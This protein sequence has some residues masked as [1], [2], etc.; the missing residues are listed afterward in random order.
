MRFV[1][2]RF[3]PSRFLAL[4]VAAFV[5]ATGAAEARYAIEPVALREAG[6]L[7][8]R[9]DSQGGLDAGVSRRVACVFQRAGRAEME[10]YNGRMDHVGSDVPMNGR[11]QDGGNSAGEMRSWIVSTPAGQFRPGMLAGAFVGGPAEPGANAGPDAKMFLNDRGDSLLLDPYGWTEP[12]P[13]AADAAA[14]MD[15]RAA[16]VGALR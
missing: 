8:C 5:L 6:M 1:N 7:T 12:A 10:Y 16:Q 11:N 14:S 3:A 4:A 9:L 13:D 15:L 2:S